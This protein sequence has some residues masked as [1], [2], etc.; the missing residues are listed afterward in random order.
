MSV[1][2]RP[3]LTM[4]AAAALWLASCSPSS[5]QNQQ[6]AAPGVSDATLAAI[7]GD[8]A[9]AGDGDEENVA[10]DT[11]DDRLITEESVGVVHSGEKL[12]AL[13]GA[14]GD[15]HIRVV[16]G[17]APDLAAICVDDDAGAE[18]F[19]A[20]YA[21]SKAPTSDTEIQMVATRHPAFRTR[22]GVGAGAALKDVEGVYGDATLVH[23][24]TSATPEYVE[25]DHGPAGSI[26]F[27]V[28]SPSN[29]KGLAGVYKDAA[30]GYNETREY[31]PDAVI[32][33]IEVRGE[34]Q[35]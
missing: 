18:L 27:R 23:N 15:A 29:P 1:I 8:D 11:P 10:Y 2:M 12:G 22:E 28:V 20:A 21:S 14:L 6:T 25:F 33:A 4:A 26:S 3:E 13:K 30:D 31:R 17:F 19:C 35:E 5:E 32:A 9:N 7:Q 24:T 34:P 16:E